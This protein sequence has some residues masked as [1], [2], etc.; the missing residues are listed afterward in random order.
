MIVR[1][2]HGWTRPA[3]TDTYEAMLEEEVFVG[4]QD[5]HIQGFKNIQLLRRPAS[6]RSWAAS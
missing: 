6:A 5:R 3:D 4:I 1:I 2:W